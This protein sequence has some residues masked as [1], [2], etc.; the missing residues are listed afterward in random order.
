M[1]AFIFTGQHLPEI[2]KVVF[3]GAP[4]DQFWVEIARLITTGVLSIIAGLA[5]IVAV[6][7]VGH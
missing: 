6:H 5:G 2:T 7:R 3:S 4:Q 1:A